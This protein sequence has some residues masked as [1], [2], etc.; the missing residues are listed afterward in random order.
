MR[1]CARVQA[2]SLA[3]GKSRVI[4][5]TGVV[6]RYLERRCG[7]PARRLTTTELMRLIDGRGDMATDTKNWL[8]DFLAQTDLI[9]YA[10]ATVSKERGRELVDEARQFLVKTS[11]PI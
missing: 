9:K 7:I 11:T 5:L 6:R 3:D 10:G 2:L 8:R 4:L 1:E